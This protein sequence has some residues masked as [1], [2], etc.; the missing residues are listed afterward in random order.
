MN[1]DFKPVIVTQCTVYEDKLHFF[2]RNLDYVKVAKKINPD[3][4][5]PVNEKY[6]GVMTKSGKRIIEKRL[7]A[8]LFAMNCFNNL[9][10]SKFDR[11]PHK[12]VFI[13]LTLSD[14]QH[15]SDKYIKRNMLQVFLKDLQYNYGVINYFWKAERQENN[16]IHFH[17]IVDKYINKSHIQNVWNRIQTAHGYTASYREKFGGNNPPST[18]VVGEK[19]N[20]SLVRYM[21]KYVSKHDNN[22]KIEGSVFR[23]S[24]SLVSL[25]PFHEIISG[26]FENQLKLFIVKNE[27]HKFVSDYCTILYF[28]KP[29]KP[30]SLPS[31]IKKYIDKYYIEL[32]H[33]LYDN[34]RSIKTKQRKSRYV[35]LKPVQQKIFEFEALPSDAVLH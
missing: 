12:P 5:K 18:H 4:I 30:H 20:R 15:H 25:K 28:R 11:K 17:L 32:Y 29:L 2:E 6:T 27:T 19:Q 8:W 24:K 14:K 34:Q 13:T 31:G 1:K 3:A 9:H 21:L 26:E 35:P 7:T 10:F 16:N 33:E 23:F 22:H